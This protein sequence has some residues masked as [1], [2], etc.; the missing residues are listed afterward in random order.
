LD[1]IN[2]HL[3]VYRKKPFVQL[4]VALL[5]ITKVSLIWVDY[6]IEN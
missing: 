2:S 1:V 3:T 4:N 5:I 6:L